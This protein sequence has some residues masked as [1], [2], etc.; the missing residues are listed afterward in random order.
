MIQ[1]YMYTIM[2]MLFG[3][4]YNVC[5]IT[6]TIAWMFLPVHCICLLATFLESC[7]VLELFAKFDCSNRYLPTSMK[8]QSLAFKRQVYIFQHKERY[9]NVK[10]IKIKEKSIHT[11]DL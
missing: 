3:T 10:Y 2:I 8:V 5:D 4:E 7:I 11:D 1:I 9:N 6:L